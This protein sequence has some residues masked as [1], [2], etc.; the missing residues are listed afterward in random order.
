MHRHAVG[1]IAVALIAG[2]AAMSFWPSLRENWPM[3]EGA[4]WRVG[5]L[6]AVA[7]LAYHDVR[8]LPA[9]MLLFAP[10][11]LLVIAFRPRWIIFL[12]PILVAIAILRPRK[13]R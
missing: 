7:W 6:M 10:F 3:F 1:I 13:K 2:A 8:R 12:L 5:A 11:V 9:W 4:F